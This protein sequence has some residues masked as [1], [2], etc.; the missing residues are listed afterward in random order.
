[1]KSLPSTALLLAVA[2]AALAWGGPAR[3]AAGDSLAVRAQ[4]VLGRHCGSCHGGPKGK[5]GLNVLDR[6]ELVSRKLIDL[7]APDSSELLDLV[8][9]GSMP[10]GKHK[11]V[12]PAE[13]RT[14]RQWIEAK[15]PG[16]SAPA[17]VLRQILRDWK[18]N[19]K[20]T[21]RYVSLA[22]LGG[23]ANAARREAVRE[24]LER[25]LKHYTSP[26]AEGGRLEAIDPG[27]LV[28]R[29]DLAALGWARRPFKQR[30]F[31]SADK[32]YEDSPINLYD[33]L[34]LEYPYGSLSFGSDRFPDVRKYLEKAATLRPVPYVRADWLV[35]QLSEGK[36][37]EEL[38]RLLE[39]AVL[40]LG[41]H[42]PPKAASAAEYRKD[43]TPAAARAELGF[44]G[45]AAV[46][47]KALAATAAKDLAGGKAVP[48][49]VWEAA[50]PEVLR[51]LGGET[52][53]LPL[54][55]LDAPGSLLNR[56]PD[57]TVSVRITDAKGQQNKTT[58]KIGESVGIVIDWKEAVVFEALRKSKREYRGRFME[59]SE[60]AEKD[61]KKPLRKVEKAG[62][63]VATDQIVV[64]AMSKEYVKEKKEYPQRW[65]VQAPEQVRWRYVHRFYEINKKGDGF[66]GPPAEKL[67]VAR[68]TFTIT[69]PQ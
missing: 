42:S 55:G 61:K 36:I 5:A 7:D 20:P 57:E 38:A 67:L 11:K 23:A 43:V 52:P 44:G 46:L 13:R 54:D 64:F 47:N 53:I 30:D 29:I 4:E 10:P 17:Y 68:G 26:K 45:D 32:G 12:S 33:L 41:D 65:E 2:C 16:E 63:D 14:L 62:L 27:K 39:L 37:G 56:P 48:R 66:A 31:F 49:A 15:A 34:L 25:L 22:H 19:E 50:Y 3:A 18:E 59:D 9:S 8:E 24:D 21:V 69:K 35:A 51:L 58:F 28:F 60:V 40:D 6:D 1:M